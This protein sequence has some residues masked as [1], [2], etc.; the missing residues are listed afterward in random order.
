MFQKMGLK[1]KLAMGFGI[2]LALLTITGGYNYVTTVR[3]I[4]KVDKA[5][6]AVKKKEFSADL[7][8]LV[9]R[10]R[11]SSE[12]FLFAGDSNALQKYQ[13]ERQ[14]IRAKLDDLSVFLTG[15]ERP[16]YTRIAT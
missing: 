15:D 5:N 3:L 6:E 10:Q 1:K 14:Q 9:R 13:N 8:L 12:D 11:R 16:L 4:S 2:L 7:E